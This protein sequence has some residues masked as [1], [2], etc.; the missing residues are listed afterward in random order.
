M[1]KFMAEV[2]KELAKEPPLIKYYGVF[3][4]QKLYEA[5]TGWYK[6][7]DFDMHE[8]GY[9]HKGKELEF[10]W[11][12]D[13][14][15][16]DYYKY[17]ITVSMFVWDFKEAEIIKN[18]E[19][20]NTHQGRIQIVVK[21]YYVLDYDKQWEGGVKEKLRGFYHKFIIDKDIIFKINKPLYKAVYSL[22]DTIRDA[23]GMEHT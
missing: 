22:Y 16:T 5:I 13:K 12:G 23:L 2:K 21:G 17:E 10:E 9:V 7:K 8:K 19:K 14:K 15:I 6:A 11:F 18:N 3:D 1:Y 4:Y 20:V